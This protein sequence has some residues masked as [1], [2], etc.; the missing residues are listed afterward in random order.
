MIKAII[1]DCFGILITDALEAMVAELREHRPEIADQVVTTVHLANRGKINRQESRK[2][3]ASLLG[4][5]AEEYV[6]RIKNGEVKGCPCWLCHSSHAT[7]L[8]S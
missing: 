8:L 6:E 1:F 4:M 5:S 2:R 3:I 7:N